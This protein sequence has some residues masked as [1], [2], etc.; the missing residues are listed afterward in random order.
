MK[1]VSLLSLL[2]TGVALIAGACQPITITI[3]QST[4]NPTQDIV[5]PTVEPSAIPTE[6][7][8]PTVE[9]S[10]TAIPTMGSI[11]GSL[12][13]PSEG[14]P[15]L[16]I[17]AYLYGTDSFYNLDTEFNQTSYELDGLPDGNYHVV[18]YTKGS[19]SF[20]AGLSGG[21]TQAVLCGMGEGCTDHSLVDVHVNAGQV[22]ENVNLIDW[23]I[24]TPPM[25]QEGQPV[26]GAITGQLSYPSEF[27]PSMRVVAFRVADK[28][29]FYVDTQ[30]N[31]GTYVLPVPAG[32][33]HVVAYVGG[34]YVGPQI[35]SGGYS[36]AV[37]CGLS[38]DCTDHTLIDV[39]VTQGSVTAGI[40]PGDF[41]A[42]QG[43]FPTPP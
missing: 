38:V 42:P 5:Q 32:T 29:P 25:P 28:K 21:Y 43:T 41:Y 7:S 6:I 34:P 31:D 20:P 9:S 26:Q 11:R 36:Q 37:P 35:I 8:T 40:D 30:I 10:P 17:V 23:L 19:E 2:F 4:S 1:N 27:I 39:M 14:I 22:V 18:A 3:G 15:E 12:G 33:Y 16:H 13:Y 24:P